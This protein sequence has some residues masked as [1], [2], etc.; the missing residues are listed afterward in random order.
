M[1]RKPDKE[2]MNNCGAKSS[3]ADAA[4]GLDDDC[5]KAPP[6]DTQTVG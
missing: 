2:L 6:P 4:A 3:L 5:L 1:W